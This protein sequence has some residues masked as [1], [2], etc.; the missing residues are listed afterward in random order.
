MSDSL[1]FS[2]GMTNLVAVRGGQPPV[3]RRSVLTLFAHRAPEVGV[4]SDNPK[5]DEPGVVLAGF[6]ERIGDPV[7]LVAPDGSKHRADSVLADA[8]DAMARA[9]SNGGPAESVSV[10]V[11][12]HWTAGTRASLRGAVATKTSLSPNGVAPSLI[13]DA[14]AALTHLQSS[15]GVPHGIVAL[16]D[17]G[18]GGTSI[19]LADTSRR[20]RYRLL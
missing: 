16:L 15:S 5:L 12:A 17:F 6:V 11:P 20:P 10:A 4:A 2:V 3:T 13:S 8:L 9:A 1:G 7:P 18:G 14:T 19:T